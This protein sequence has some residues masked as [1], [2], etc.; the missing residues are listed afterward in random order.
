MGEIAM[1]K[2]TPYAQ[3]IEV[4]S[5]FGR[6]DYMYIKEIAPWAYDKINDWIKVAIQGV[7][8]VD[9]TDDWAR[10][11]GQVD[12]ARYAGSACGLLNPVHVGITVAGAIVDPRQI[13]ALT[14][15][16][17]VSAAQ[18]GVWSVG[19]TW[20]L[21]ALDIVSAAQ[22]G[23]W[24]V[25]RTWALAVATDAVAAQVSNWP[26][27]YAMN[28]TQY[29]SAAC[30]LLNPI[31]VGVTVAGAIV[32]PRSIRALTAA[33]IIT[34]DSL[35]KWGGT[36]LTGRDITADLRVLSDLAKTPTSV[37]LVAAT[38]KDYHL[39]SGSLFSLGSYVS[40]GAGQLG[41]YLL[42]NPVGSGKT[43]KIRTVFLVSAVGCGFCFA[44]DVNPANQGAALTPFNRQRGGAASVAH[45][46]LSS[47]A[48]AF[49]NT[50]WLDYV[51]MP[52]PFPFIYDNVNISLDA[53]HTLTIWTT[54]AAASMNVTV[55]WEE[56]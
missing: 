33:D 12:L 8:S 21:T 49:P 26:A 47:N 39:E 13:R 34:A 37:E 18:S 2:K 55:I 9:I 20:T 50:N 43:L 3:G 51:A 17:V 52:T 36:A 44:F 15:L 23:V 10:Q 27:L 32:D 45:V 25:G 24:S 38:E 22:S 35:T 5:A 41:A 56:I 6:T 31:H 19:R 53:N 16:D 14:A 4:E 30:G 1:V 40:P 48:G 54:T 11:L 28:L 42:Q 46:H 7:V 29:L